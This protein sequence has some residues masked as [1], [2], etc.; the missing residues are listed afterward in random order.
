MLN[1]PRYEKEYRL[2]CL[3]VIDIDDSERVKSG[4]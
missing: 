4:I 2:I 1:N 3:I